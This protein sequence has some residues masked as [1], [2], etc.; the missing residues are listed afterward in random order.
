LP[1]AGL[2]LLEESSAVLPMTPPRTKFTIKESVKATLDTVMAAHHDKYTMTRTAAL[3]ELKK[4]SMAVLSNL[5]IVMVVPF[6]SMTVISARL[7]LETTI[8]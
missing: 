1:V 3:Y 7:T 8:K 5:L 4:I 6:R 2:S